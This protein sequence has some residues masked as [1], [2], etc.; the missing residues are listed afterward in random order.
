MHTVRIGAVLGAALA[1]FAGAAAANAL[2][3]V[4]RGIPA[5]ATATGDLSVSAGWNGAAPSW[6]N[7]MPGSSS[8]AA[9]LRVVVEAKGDT[10]RWALKVQLGVAPEF[11]DWVTMT[12]RVGDCNTGAIVPSTGTGYVPPQG[13]LAPGATIDV[14]VRLSLSANAPSSLAGKEISPGVTAIVEQRSG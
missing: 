7:A 1:V 14:C 8:T 12:A 13:G 10:L 4:Q 11:T 5:T 3:G 6:T 2:W 9:T